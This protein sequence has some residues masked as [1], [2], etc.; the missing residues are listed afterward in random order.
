MA[1]RV[2]R[3]YISQ[4][5]FAGHLTDLELHDFD[6]DFIE[7]WLLD[8]EN[9]EKLY[10]HR[11]KM[12]MTKAKKLR[13][14][15]KKHNPFKVKKALICDLFEDYGSSVR[16]QTSIRKAAAIHLLNYNTAKSMV[17]AYLGNGCR[18]RTPDEP[19]WLSL[20]RSCKL[21]QHRDFILG[22]NEAWKN[23]SLLQRV[24]MLREHG[25]YCCTFTLR[26]FYLLNNIRYLK[27]SYS[28]VG[29]HSDEFLLRR[30]LKFVQILMQHYMNGFEILFT[31]STSTHVWQKQI[32]Y[33]QNR[34]C[35]IKLKLQGRR[36][37][38]YT[39][40]GCISSVQSRIITSVTDGTD[41]RRIKPFTRRIIRY[42]L[43]PRQTVLVMDNHSGYRNSEHIQMILDSGITILFTPP[44]SSPLNAIV[45]TLYFP[46]THPHLPSHHQPA[47]LSTKPPNTRDL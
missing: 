19:H 1:V 7:E 22:Q 33:W 32:R 31:D 40:F 39:I 46:S 43:N 23:D 16:T 15:T 24:R 38:G 8:F 41:L 28:L 17:R 47:T 42:C 4:S 14:S 36:E 21:D 5:Y 27:A 34:A 29:R 30:Q 6:N 45:S 35:P 12:E 10:R 2:V 26:R 18:F 25:I 37:R 13:Q 11:V 9:T 3:H 20:N 44:Q